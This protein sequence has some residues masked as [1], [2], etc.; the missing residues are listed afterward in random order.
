[1][2][3]REDETI[4]RITPGSTTAS[5]CE[6]LSFSVSISASLE[7]R[8]SSNPA[9]WAQFIFHIS[10]TLS[11]SRFNSSCRHFDSV[12]KAS[13]WLCASARAVRR[14]STST[15][16]L[17]TVSGSPSPDSDPGPLFDSSCTWGSTSTNTPSA[18]LNKMNSS[19]SL[20]SSSI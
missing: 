3:A 5:S 16:V 17:A 19:S 10:L 6:T 2:V 15:A 1:M 18:S 9:N 7:D 12:S 13:F 8:A 11:F 4:G 20:N 14:V